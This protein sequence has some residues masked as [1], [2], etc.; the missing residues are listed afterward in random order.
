MQV[1]EIQLRYFKEKL[2]EAIYSMA[3]GPGDVRSRLLT[4]SSALVAIKE[5]DIPSELRGRWEEFHAGLTKYGPV[6]DGRGETAVGAIEHTLQ[7]IKNSTGVG[8]AVCL[9][10][11][12][13]ELE[14]LEERQ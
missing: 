14:N 12:L 8:L 2:R 11:L 6:K 13:S 4:A 3:V 7:R 10:E 1:G 9:Y 5:S